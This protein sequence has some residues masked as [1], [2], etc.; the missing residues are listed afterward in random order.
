MRITHKDGYISGSYWTTCPRCGFEYRIEEMVIEYTDK[1]V[2]QK[3]CD[4]D[5][6]T[7]SKK[8]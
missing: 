4:E 3:C 7:T 1:E 6:K 2:C 5:P 8:Y